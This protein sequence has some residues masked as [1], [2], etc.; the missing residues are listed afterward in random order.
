MHNGNDDHDHG[1]DDDGD[2]DDGNDD[3]DDDDSAMDDANTSRAPLPNAEADG[4][5]DA[6]SEPQVTGVI[7][8]KRKKTWRPKASKAARPVIKTDSSKKPTPRV[9]KAPAKMSYGRG[10]Q[11]KQ[12]T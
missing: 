4:S 12:H 8:P 9:R 5:S 11:Q 6:S 2:D 3:D 10:W 1:N 7:P